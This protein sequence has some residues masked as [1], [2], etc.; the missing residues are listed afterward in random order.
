MTQSLRTSFWRH[1]EEQRGAEG[2]APSEPVSRAPDLKIPGPG[3]PHLMTVARC[4]GLFTFEFAKVV[5]HLQLPDSFS[6]A[7]RAA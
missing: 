6:D 1:R 7:G 4:Q 5:T 2:E 3:R